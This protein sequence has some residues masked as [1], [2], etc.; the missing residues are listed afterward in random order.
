MTEAQES[1]LIV[2]D[3]VDN[4]MI[5]EDL[6]CGHY[7]VHAAP[8]GREALDFL[9]HS[10]GIDLIL[11]DVLMPEVDGFEVCRRVKADHRLRNIP[12][13][14]LSSLESAAD[15][16]AGLSLGAED[17]IHKPFS[18]P[19]VLARVQ[20]HLKISRMTRLLKNRNEDLE[21][22]V[23]ERTHQILEQSEELMRQKQEVIVAQGATITAF[24]SLAE[25]RDNETGNHIRRTQHYVKT[26]AEQLRDHHRFRD[27][28]NDEVI[29][30]LFKSAPMH[31]IGKVAIP[32]VILHKPGKFDPEEWAEMQRHC[33]YGRNAI[34][35]AEVELGQ[36][37]S[38]F[39]RYAREIAYCHHEKWDGSGYP[40]G[41]KGE[42]IPL[43][44]RLMA[45]ADV[46]DALISERVYKPAYPHEQAM[47]MILEGRGT[48]FDPDMV[49]ALM[50]IAPSF[51]A[52][53]QRF[54][55]EELPAEKRPQT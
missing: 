6:L 34:A 30:L 19:V 15:E 2:D 1:I 27:Q 50:E 42:D 26:L 45:V 52:I 4:L 17:F 35:Q 41:L 32:D 20:N 7:Q 14:F 18:P 13:L 3:Q 22:L 48:H 31:D 16:A 37:R 40:Q 23:V 44:A 24:C 5:L 49:D 29:Q 12:V 46:Y 36:E 11:L 8:G 21:Q 25:A 39:L 38:Q 28:L 9:V 47:A 53:A 51:K 55:D 54:S 43:S 10:D 33:E